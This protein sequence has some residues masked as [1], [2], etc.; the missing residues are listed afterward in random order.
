[1]KVYPLTIIADRYS[2][3][4]SRAKFTAWNHFVEDVPEEPDSGDTECDRFWHDYK[5]PVGKGSTPDE[6]LADLAKQL[7]E[8]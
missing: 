8:P 6:A 4:Y 3:V 7:E 1:M 5:G 2:G